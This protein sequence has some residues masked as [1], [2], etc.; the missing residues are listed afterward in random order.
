MSCSTRDTS[1]NDLCK[2]ILFTHW[3][4]STK[5]CSNQPHFIFPATKCGQV[6]FETAEVT[7]FTTYIIFLI[8]FFT[9][10]FFSDIYRRSN[11]ISLVFFLLNH[12][13]SDIYRRSNEISQF[14]RILT[15]RLTTKVRSF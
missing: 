8:S 9:E 1:P 12:F 10:S 7:H 14:R 2:T 6:F 13:F 4:F 5:L 11:E 3:H 15:S